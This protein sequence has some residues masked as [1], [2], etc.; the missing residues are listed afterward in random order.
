[1]EGRA[2]FSFAGPAA[3]A[4]LVAP[5]ARSP[6][7]SSSMRASIS[8]ER[9]D[10]RLTLFLVFLL[11]AVRCPASDSLCPLTA[12]PSSAFRSHEDDMYVAGEPT[13]FGKRRVLRSPAGRR[14]AISF[15]G[16]RAAGAVV[17]G[18]TTCPAHDLPVDRDAGL[19]HHTATVATGAHHRRVGGG[20]AAA[21]ASVMSAWRR[22]SDGGWLVASRRPRVGLVGLSR[23]MSRPIRAR[24]PDC[25]LSLPFSLT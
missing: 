20:S 7:A 19:R 25:R 2:D 22:R 24:R 4:E 17:V 11:R 9:L 15:A 3:M 18:K 14:Q 8:S 5:R 6:C 16:L 13:Q 21:V 10:L 23:A 12:R 1:M